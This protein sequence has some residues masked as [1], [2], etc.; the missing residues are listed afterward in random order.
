ME[1]SEVEK[2][3]LLRSVNTQFFISRFG[4]LNI[5]NGLRPG[6]IHILMG[7]T[8][9]GKTTIAKAIMEDIAKTKKVLVY[10]SEETEDDFSYQI[11]S[12]GL[13]SKAISNLAIY[14]EQ[15]NDIAMGV[16]QT[17]S[18]MRELIKQH[19]PAVMMLDN[20]TTLG[21]YEGTEKQ[22]QFAASIKKLANDSG[23]PVLCVAH[24]TTGIGNYNQKMISPDDLRGN[25]KL[26][27]IAPYFYCFQMF[28]TSD[29]KKWPFVNIQ[30]CRAPNITDTIYAL[31]Y[32]SLK[33]I[34]I[35][36]TKIS[37]SDVKEIYKSRAAL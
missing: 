22:V 4:F 16:E 34:H 3:K 12:S 6:K 28:E 13:D 20:V 30:K 25:R 10:L 21:C 26:A 17:I 27:M 18:K 14:A 29:G 37:F 23:I 19:R 31:R 15:D 32:V 9:S 24:T 8:G 1:I 33:N 7:S 5:H 35:G 11:I 36:D 2:L